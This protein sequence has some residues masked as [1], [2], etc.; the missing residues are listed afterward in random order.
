MSHP[1]EQPQFD[2]KTQLNKDFDHDHEKHAGHAHAHQ[3]EGEEGHMHPQA[4]K[5]SENYDFNRI[6]PNWD[7][8]EKHGVYFYFFWI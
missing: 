8:A 4:H 3:H 2:E 6:P 7:E 1:E 5:H